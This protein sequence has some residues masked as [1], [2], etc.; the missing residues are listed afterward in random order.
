[1]FRFA[2]AGCARL[3]PASVQ[4][5]DFCRTVYVTGQVNAP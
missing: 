3:L 5:S 4:L 1:L 2:E